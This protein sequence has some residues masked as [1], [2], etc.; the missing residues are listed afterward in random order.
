MENDYL[1]NGKSLSDLLI[2][3]GFINYN[4]HRYASDRNYENKIKYLRNRIVKEYPN[5]T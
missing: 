1:I 5:L 4:G 3:G 2:P